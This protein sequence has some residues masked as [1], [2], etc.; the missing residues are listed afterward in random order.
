MSCFVV[1][2]LTDTSARTVNNRKLEQYMQKFSKKKTKQNTEWRVRISSTLLICS[3]TLS[4]TLLQLL[5]SG[6][7]L[8]AVQKTLRIRKHAG[9]FRAV[10]SSHL[11]LRRTLLFI[12]HILSA[13]LCC[14]LFMLTTNFQHAQVINPGHSC[15]IY[16]T[17]CRAGGVIPC[18]VFTHNSCVLNIRRCLSYICCFTSGR[19]GLK[20]EGLRELRELCCSSTLSTLSTITTQQHRGQFM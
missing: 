16:S 10:D 11:G 8:T 15:C 13:R 2:K 6:C 18:V 4:V 9:H 14:L 1:R 17:P 3:K 5:T 7:P 12:Y 19:Q 20:T